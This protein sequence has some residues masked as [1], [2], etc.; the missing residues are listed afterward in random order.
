MDISGD[1]A[2]TT[3]EERGG[4][5]RKVEK[6]ATLALFL[7]S[8]FVLVGFVP[9]STDPFS[10]IAENALKVMGADSVSIGGVSVVL[11]TGLRVR[12]ISTYKRISDKGDGYRAS[13]AHA[14]V[15]CN[16]IR[17]AFALLVNPR[18]YRHGRDVFREA[19]ERPFELAGDV[20]RAVESLRP[21]KRIV[22]SGAG[23]SFT[24]K[25]ASGVSAS[26]AEVTLGRDGGPALS[27]NVSVRAVVIPALAKVDNFRVK[28]S[29]DDKK[30]EL[31]DGVGMVF[32]GRLRM[33][34]SVDVRQSEIS[35]GEMFVSGLDLERFCAGTGFSPGSLAGKVDFEARVDG[36][37]PI[38]LDSV[39]AK[40]LVTVTNLTAA[41][42]ALQKSPVVNQL[43]R[44]LRLLRFSEVRGGFILSGGKLRF[45]EIV[46]V[47]D[48]LKFRSAGW[49]GLDGKISQDFEGELSRN[50]VAGLPKLIKNSLEKTEDEGGRFKCKI[51]GTFHKP[52]IEVDKSV[53]DR[54]IGG[55]FKG[56]FK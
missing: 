11:W 21:V 1:N 32:G 3:P 18:L 54:A 27:G 46:G 14:D 53:Y 47:G 16:L 45:R 40:G 20:S 23:I 9:I 39:K 25:G 12:D 41:D 44:D 13:A 51:G 52:R 29:I 37:S 33:G 24:S 49:V 7:L 35:S 43:S 2:E 17:A 34:L 26:G 8:I 36:G 4:R 50:F 28:V 38:S 22:L 10:G 6:T 19:Y 56:L 30:L 55:F 31:A 48:V 15:R 42:L 5:G